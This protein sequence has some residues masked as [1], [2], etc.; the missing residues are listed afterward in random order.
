MCIPKVY[1]FGLISNSL[2]ISNLKQNKQEE[3]E[4]KA[5]KV[6]KSIKNRVGKQR[7]SIRGWIM[8]NIFRR[9][10]LSENASWNPTDRDWWISQGWTGSTSPWSKNNNC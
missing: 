7:I 1:K 2:G 9:M 8:F 3:I 5:Y 10:Q 4:K 6:A